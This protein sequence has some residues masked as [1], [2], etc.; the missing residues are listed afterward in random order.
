MNKPWLVKAGSWLGLRAVKWRLPFANIAVKKT[1]F[2][3]FC[4][5]TT[6][7]ECGEKIEKLAQF[8]VLTVLDYGAEAKETEMDFNHTM[9]EAIRAL[10]FAA[11]SK[12]IPVV[13]AK[14]TGMGRAELLERISRQEIL[15]QEEEKEYNHLVKRID[16]VCYAASER[17]V[18]VYIDGEESWVQDAI[19]SLVDKMMARYNR[20]RVV[21]YNTFQMYRHDRLDF[22]KKSFIKSRQMGYL[23]GAK[24]V[25]GAYMEKERRRAAAMN[26][27]S[28][29]NLDKAA[30]DQLYDDGIAFCIENID[31]VA[32]CNASHNAE[33]ALRQARLME[34]KSIP[35]HHP[36]LFF[37]QLYGMSDNLTFNLAAAGYRVGKYM[38]YGTVREVIPYLLRRAQE[39]T[40]VTGDMSRE[41]QLIKKEATRRG[42]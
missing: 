30:T 32:V 34:E 35:H 21:V 23:L 33:S 37:S 40:S 11:R 36:H 4:G 26:Y 15:S 9:N 7:L 10:D 38:P 18:S 14:T 20:E 25:R 22:L 42:I 2:E 3:Q 16:A 24:L 29:I 12:T 8:Q 19:D 13:V 28:P 31:Y 17:G 27:L 41:F 5:G 6:L 1:I 39:N